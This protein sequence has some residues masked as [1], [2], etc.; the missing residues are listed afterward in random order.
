M[1]EQQG[2]TIIDFWNKEMHNRVI[3]YL[4][5]IYL[6]IIFINKFICPIF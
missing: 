4:V 2:K 3:I 1:I 6:L 5:I